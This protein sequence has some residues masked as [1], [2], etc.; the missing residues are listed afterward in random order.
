[1]EDGVGHVFGHIF[2]AEGFEDLFHAGLGE[3]LAGGEVLLGFD[4]EFGEGFGVFRWEVVAGLVFSEHHDLGGVS[5]HIGSGDGDS[6][7]ERVDGEEADVAGVD[8]EVGAVEPG[9]DLGFFVDG[10]GEVGEVA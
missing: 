10:S 1:M 8:A 5:G 6:V 7:G 9:C 2:G 3:A 4:E